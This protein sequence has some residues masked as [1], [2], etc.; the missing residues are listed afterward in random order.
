[1]DPEPLNNLDWRATSLVLRWVWLIVIFAVG[2]ST[3]MV[4]THAMIPSLLDSG[5]IPDGLRERVR[6]LRFPLYVMAFFSIAFIAVWFWFAADSAHEIR[7][8]WHRDWI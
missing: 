6:K 1:M 4:L 7:R 5:H 2:F 3:V 8:F